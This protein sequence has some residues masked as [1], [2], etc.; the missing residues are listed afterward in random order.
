MKIT[1]KQSEPI[2]K[3]DIDYVLKQSKKGL[4][5]EEIRKLTI[6]KKRPNGL[7]TQSI[8]IIRNRYKIIS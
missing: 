1:K 6:S 3:R 7:S 4:S 8:H 5:C 2:T